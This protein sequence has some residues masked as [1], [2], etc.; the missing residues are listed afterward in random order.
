MIAKAGGLYAITP[1]QLSDAALFEA[2]EQ[3]LA[4]GAVYL[5]YRAKQKPASQREREAKQLQQLCKVTGAQFIVNDDMLL[6]AKLGCG[7]HVGEGDCSVADARKALGAAAIIGASCYDS[8]ARAEQAS[9]DGASYLAFGAFYESTTKR[10]TRQASFEL[11]AQARAFGLPL[12]AIGGIT[13]AKATALINA[14]ADYLAVVS[15]LF[16]RTESVRQQ[17]EAFSACFSAK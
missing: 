12:V 2:C 6:A 1:E 5:Q 15:A 8:L 13:V 17:A 16:E 14:G 10:N 11:L 9:A 7:L 3:A 4:G